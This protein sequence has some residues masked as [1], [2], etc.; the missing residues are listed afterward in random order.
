MTKKQIE[1]LIRE[2][3]ETA[4]RYFNRKDGNKEYTTGVGDGCQHAATLLSRKL[5]QRQTKEGR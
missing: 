4:Q 3:D 2:L 5:K 1:E